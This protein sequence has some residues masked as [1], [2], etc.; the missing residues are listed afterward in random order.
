MFYKSLVTSI[1]LYGCETWTLFADA[2]KKDLCF[3]NQKPEETSPHLLLGAQDQRL[4]AEQD[5][6]PC[7]STGTS[8]GKCQETETCMV[9]ACHDSLSKTILHGTLNEWTSLPMPELLTSAFCRTDW[10]R[11]SAESSFM[12][13]RRLVGQGFELD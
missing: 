8:S 6:R 5:Q 3:Q 13:V 9:R 1:L 7:G 12:S 11:I 10:K 4:G 2:E